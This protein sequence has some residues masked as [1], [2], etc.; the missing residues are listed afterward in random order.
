MAV[1]T[2]VGNLTAFEGKKI[3]T[4]VLII[5]VYIVRHIDLDD[6]EPCATG[7]VDRQAS[8]A[9]IAFMNL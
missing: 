7:L 1:V 6:V 5:G 2:A 3:G 8:W 9:K 4:E